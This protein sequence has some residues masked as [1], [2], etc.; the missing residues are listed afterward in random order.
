[1]LAVNS[2]EIRPTAPE[3]NGYRIRGSRGQPCNLTHLS[4]INPPSWRD[5][6][7]VETRVDFEI[8]SVEV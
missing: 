3:K 1:M 5:A 8:E 6:E 7:R 2:G 4:G